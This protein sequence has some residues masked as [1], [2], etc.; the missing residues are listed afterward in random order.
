MLGV[1][2]TFIG[3]RCPLRSG[4]ALRSWHF[5]YDLILYFVCLLLYWI[6]A[7]KSSLWYY[8]FCI[9]FTTLHHMTPS[10]D[11][12]R[13]WDIM[14]RRVWLWLDLWDWCV[15]PVGSM[16]YT[17]LYTLSILFQIIGWTWYMSMIYCVSESLVNYKLTSVAHL[18]KLPILFIGIHVFV[19]LP[20]PDV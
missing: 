11:W 9:H 10:L 19:V 8:V 4:P 12:F 14:R 17:Y 16:R 20:Y 5:W 18:T 1:F 3:L 6:I 7:I 13:G 15:T 2:L